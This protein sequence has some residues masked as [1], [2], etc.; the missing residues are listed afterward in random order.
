MTLAYDYAADNPFT[1]RWT[2]E[3]LPAPAPAPTLADRARGLADSVDRHT[4]TFYARLA[5]I[6]AE[7]AE[8]VEG[9][10]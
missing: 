6:V 2:A 7:L 10:S 5:A 9:E 3:P 1:S 4:D 8:K